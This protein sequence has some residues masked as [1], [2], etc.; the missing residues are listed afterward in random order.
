MP[1]EPNQML[2]HYRLV[3]ILGQRG[4]GHVCRAEDTKLPRRP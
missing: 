1:L 2:A 4:L 3:E